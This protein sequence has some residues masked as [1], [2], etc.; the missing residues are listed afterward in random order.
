MWQDTLFAI[1]SELG[2]SVSPNFRESQR[3][4]AASLRSERSLHGHTYLFSQGRWNGSSQRGPA[5]THLLVF[6][7]C[8]SCFFFF[9]YSAFKCFQN[10]RF[11]PLQ[12]RTERSNLRREEDQMTGEN[13]SSGCASSCPTLTTHF[14]CT[15][16]AKR[17]ITSN[18]P[19]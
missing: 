7:L 8:V 19:G 3:D 9:N 17:Q 6:L 1:Y 15:N 5:K 12:R 4:P 10:K 13:T 14:D 11:Q 18:P 2:A 16:Q